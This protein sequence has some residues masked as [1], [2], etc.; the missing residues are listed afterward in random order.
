M[1]RAVPCKQCKKTTWAGC[2]AHI[3]QVLGH[4]PAGQRCQCER[5]KGG[6]MGPSASHLL[7]RVRKLLGL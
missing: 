5:G 1:C 4:L 3:E 7:D 2:G 6:G